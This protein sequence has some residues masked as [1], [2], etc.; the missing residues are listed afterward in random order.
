VVAG[1]GLSLVIE[2]P[3]LRL[4][5]VLGGRGRD[6]RERGVKESLVG[7]MSH[8]VKFIDTEEITFSSQSDV[9]ERV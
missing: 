5:K 4:E 6:G 8:E 2:S 3:I 7:S 1:T 9:I